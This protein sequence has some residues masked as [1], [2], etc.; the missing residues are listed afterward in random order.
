MN[1]CKGLILMIYLPA[2][3]KNQY[4]DQIEEDLVVTE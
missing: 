3:H 2:D 4:L 1:D